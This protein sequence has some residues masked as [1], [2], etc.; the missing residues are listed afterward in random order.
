MS[1]LVLIAACL[2][3]SSCNNDNSSKKTPYG[4]SAVESTSFIDTLKPIANGSVIENYPNQGGT[5][6]NYW[7]AADTNNYGVN[8]MYLYN[9][10]ATCLDL[11][12]TTNSIPSGATIDSI[13]VI[14]NSRTMNAKGA[15]AGS[16]KLAV[17]EN[18]TT[19][20]GTQYSLPVQSSF[21]LFREAWI[22]KASD[23]QPF[24]KA[25]IDAIEYGFSQTRGTGT[26]NPNTGH[27]YL[28]VYYT[29]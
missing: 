9:T 23:G 3:F 19:T 1:I 12:T 29:N 7:C 16:L 26:S 28:V 20:L 15:G 6:M 18:S 13:A 4:T 14:A 2:S 21:P 24:T 22:V 5:G 8:N 25:D 27:V 10:A 17:R 11:Y